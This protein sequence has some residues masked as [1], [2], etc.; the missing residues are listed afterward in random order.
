MKQKFRLVL[1]RWLATI[2]SAV[3]ILFFPAF[4]VSPATAEFPESPITR[5][6]GHRPFDHSHEN[7]QKEEKADIFNQK[8]RYQPSRN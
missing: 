1:S 2:L 4:D 6:T 8:H 3:S 5:K 7:T